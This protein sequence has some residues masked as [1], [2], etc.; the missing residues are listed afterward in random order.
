MN[1]RACNPGS[2]QFES[3]NPVCLRSIG[4]RSKGDI[5]RI[6]DNTRHTT[7]T[8]IL[9]SLLILGMSLSYIRGIRG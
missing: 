8:P 2:I 7:L 9:T 3:L 5:K 6:L 4:E 1:H